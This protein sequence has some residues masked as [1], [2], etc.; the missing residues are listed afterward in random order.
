M[1]VQSGRVTA[2]CE[3]DQ[4]YPCVWAGALSSTFPASGVEAR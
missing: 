2:L 3:S 1:H 4:Q